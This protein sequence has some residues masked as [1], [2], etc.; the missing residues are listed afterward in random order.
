MS[1]VGIQKRRQEDVG[2]PPWAK[3]ALAVTGTTVTTIVAMFL[4]A[5]ATFVSR[6]EWT[7][8]AAQQSIDLERIIA[9]QRV[10]A[11]QERDTA[12]ALGAINVKLGVIEA[13]QL[14]V[15]ERLGPINGNGKK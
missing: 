11:E 5:S 1:D 6:V 10:Y 9:T 15:L 7:A 14:M 13:R 3:L 12:S 2:L 4:W 8:H